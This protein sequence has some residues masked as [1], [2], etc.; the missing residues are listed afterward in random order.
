MFWDITYIPEIGCPACPGRSLKNNMASQSAPS[1]QSKRQED[2]CATYSMTSLTPDQTQKHPM[3]D[4]RRTRAL[5]NK[6]Y[7]RSAAYQKHLEARKTDVAYR[8]RVFKEQAKR[9]NTNVSI[10]FDEY[11]S[12]VRSAC[13]YCGDYIYKGYSG[14]NRVHNAGTYQKDNVVASCKTCNFM[15]ESL[16]VTEFLGKVER[17]ARKQHATS[18]GK[19]VIISEVVRPQI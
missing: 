12:I 19:A 11:G 3:S 2:T 15:K 6:R 9:R 5:Q 16:S 17:I 13:W 7:R 14:A 18:T 8:W 10:S 4:K 1:K